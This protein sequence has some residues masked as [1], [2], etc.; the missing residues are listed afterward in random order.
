MILAILF[1]FAELLFIFFG[2][3]ALFSQIFL[4][5]TSPNSIWREVKNN[6]EASKMSDNNSSSGTSATSMFLGLAS[7]GA[8]A[9]LG[10]CNAQGIPIDNEN[11]HY[12]LKYGPTLVR[13]A[14][15]GVTLGLVGAGVGGYMG[16]S[17]GSFM[18]SKLENIARGAGGA[19]AG[20]AAGAALGGACG[21]ATGGIQTLIGYAVGYMAGAL[22][23]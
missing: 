19:V 15:S 6:T 4:N 20:G 5:F 18:S 13:G 9:Y 11:L 22:V 1:L 23:R 21:A 3:N 7:I 17:S 14:V 8:G 2:K 10:Y 16:G 12:A